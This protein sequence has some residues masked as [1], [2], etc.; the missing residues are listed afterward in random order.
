LREIISP[1]G[2]LGK[3]NIQY[4]GKNSYGDCILYQQ[5][6]DGLPDQLTLINR[7]IAE[8]KNEL[9]ELDE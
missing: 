6:K 8:E 2:M 7:E 9:K 5:G 4:K 1:Y 3:G